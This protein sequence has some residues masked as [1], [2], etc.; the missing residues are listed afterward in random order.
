MKLSEGG[1]PGKLDTKI[2]SA[3]FKKCSKALTSP[4]NSLTISD[5]VEF[6]ETI[7]KL[8]PMWFTSTYNELKYIQ[9]RFME[10]QRTQYLNLQD[11]VKFSKIFNPNSFKPNL[12]FSLMINTRPRR[13]DE[14]GQVVQAP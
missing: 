10:I 2:V 14:N 5:H 12:M 13:L 3:M 8:S 6:Y 7:Y 1:K 4:F 11:A 9:A